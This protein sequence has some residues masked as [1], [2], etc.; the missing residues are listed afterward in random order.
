MQC[1]LGSSCC[2]CLRLP[3][4]L[5]TPSRQLACAPNAIGF[6]S[7]GREQ[8]NS[9]AT[10]VEDHIEACILGH[11]CSQFIVTSR[12]ILPAAVTHPRAV[13]T[14]KP[15]FEPTTVRRLPKQWAVP[16]VYRLPLSYAPIAHAIRCEGPLTSSPGTSRVSTMNPTLSRRATPPLLLQQ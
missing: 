7:L 1:A 2:I 3:T 12:R 16:D 15:I 9:A 14:C 4:T 10:Q 13:Q 5:E 6:V 11:G 8:C